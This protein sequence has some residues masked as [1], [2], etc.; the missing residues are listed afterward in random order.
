MATKT[1][2][3]VPGLRIAAPGGTF[4]RAGLQF[5]SEPRELPVADLTEAQ[6]QALRAEPALV[7]LDVTL[8]PPAAAG[9]QA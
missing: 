1:P 3:G 4:R 5:G 9:E 8:P 2:A 7:V 6:V